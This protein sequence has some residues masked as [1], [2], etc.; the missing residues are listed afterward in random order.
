[1]EVNQLKAATSSGGSADQATTQNPQTAAPQS[2][3]A[4]APAQ[5]VQPGTATSLLAS[6]TGL[7]L[8][9]GALTTV[10]LSSATASQATAT[11]PAAKPLQS[12][13]LNPILLVLSI[14]LCVVAVVLFWIMSRSAKNTTYSQ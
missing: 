6:Q 11:K 8:T 9:P 10:D 3:N 13:H 14:G 2:D 4:A 7:A 5:S 12:Q 1:M